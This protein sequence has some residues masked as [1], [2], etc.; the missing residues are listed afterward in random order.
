[1]PFNYTHG[2]LLYT[3]ILIYTYGPRE[4]TNLKAYNILI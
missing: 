4:S 3:Y 1:M 2:L